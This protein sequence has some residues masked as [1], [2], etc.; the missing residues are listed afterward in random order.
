M[1]LA[2]LGLRCS[3]ALAFFSGL[4]TSLW[5]GGVETMTPG[6]GGEFSCPRSALPEN[7]AVTPSPLQENPGVFELG[8]G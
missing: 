8:G 2:P 4:G 3:K 1:A 7:S 6:L 5:D